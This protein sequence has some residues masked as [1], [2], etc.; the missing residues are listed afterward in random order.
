MKFVQLVLDKSRHWV[1]GIIFLLGL[2]AIVSSCGP[3]YVSR[4]VYRAT[5]TTQKAANNYFIAKIS[6]IC[7]EY[8]CWAFNLTIEN[9]S[10]KDIELDWNKTLY[11]SNGTTE[12]GFMFDGVVF[13]D[14]N[15]SKPPDIIFAGSTFV[16]IISPNNL[17]SF[18]NGWNQEHMPTGENGVYLTVKVGNQEV[19]EKL[20]LI[21]HKELVE[22]NGDSAEKKRVMEDDI[23]LKIV[24]E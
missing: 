24:V 23:I 9:K 12:G 22:K 16:K 20:T 8:G 7:G 6:P 3:S 17:V 21:L 14:R 2:F 10:H 5:P 13:K 1:I 19:H 4:Y 11:I 18:N 15:N